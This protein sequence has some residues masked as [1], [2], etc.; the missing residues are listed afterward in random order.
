LSHAPA[1]AI[2]KDDNMGEM[3]RLTAEDGHEFDA[4]QASPDE[5]PR[6]GLVIIQEVFGVTDHIKRVTDGYAAE[7]Y[8][9][10]APALFD[11]VSPGI[12]VAYDDVERGRDV[13]L[14]LDLEQVV[15]DVDAAVSKAAEA[16]PVGAVGYCWGG[17]I[18]DLAACRLPVKVAVAYYGGRLTSWLDEKPRCPVLYHFGGQDPLIPAETVQQIRGGRPDGVIYLYP[19]AGHGFNCDEREDYDAVSAEQALKRSLSFIESA[20]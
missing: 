3:V 7:G 6:G 5:T 16:G 4:Y 2:H 17:A 11:R 15:L 8:L 10:I 18:A 9:A 14:Q 20:L 1:G 12:T 19:E 13:M